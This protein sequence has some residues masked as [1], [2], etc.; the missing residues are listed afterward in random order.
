MAVKSFDIFD[1]CLVRTCGTPRGFYDVLSYKVFSEDVPEDVR[2]AFAIARKKA[3][4]KVW[5]DN[6]KLSLAD[7]YAALP[8]S[9][10]ALKSVDQL[11]QLELSLEKAVLRPSQKA[12]QKIDTFRNKGN[13]IVFISDMYLPSVFLKEI[14]TSF[15]LFVDGDGM[16]VSCEYGATKQS[17]ELFRVVQRIEGIQFSKWHHYGD[18]RHN[19]VDMPR[20]LGIKATLFENE[21]SHYQKQ[22]MNTVIPKAFD[23]SGITA[24]LSRAISMSEEDDSHKEFVLDLIAP[25]YCS[26]VYNVLSDAASKGIKRL[27]FC[28]RDAYQIFVIAQRMSRLFPQINLEYLYISRDSLYNGGE[29]AKLAYFEEIGLAS[30]KDRSAIV[31]ITTSGKTLLELN[32]FLERNGYSKVFGYY[33]LLWDDPREIPVDESLSRFE[34]RAAN[35]RGNKRAETFLNHIYLFENF[36][37]LNNQK[38]TVDYIIDEGKPMPVFSDKITEIESIHQDVEMWS[39]R[40]SDLLTKYAESFIDC[41]LYSFSHQIMRELSF[42]TLCSFCSLPETD[43]LNA[44]TEYWVFSGRVQ[45][46]VPYVRKE[47]LLRICLD[48]GA[49]SVWKTATIY[50]SLPKA[51]RGIYARYR[52]QS[53]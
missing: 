39:G 6:P 2:K 29:E 8:F 40:L 16:Y 44:L 3:E 49:N 46:H 35:F 5:A 47:S 27:F 36:F 7:I 17:G 10:S 1:T 11:I 50:W 18:S 38:K 31:D 37:A 51:L 9:H 25:F 48:R 4:D 32:K 14:L 33:L 19:D 22:W 20:S 23:Y 28:A 24:G 53:N 41:G 42:P 45:K 12:K 52:L 34:F 30:R 26:Y 21:Y 43:Y 13:R 15:G